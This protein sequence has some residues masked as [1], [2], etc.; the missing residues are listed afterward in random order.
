[1]Q[2]QLGLQLAS[3]NEVYWTRYAGIRMD[4]R[5]ESSMAKRIVGKSCCDETLRRHNFPWYGVFMP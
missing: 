1:M 3:S 5:N 4:S 2:I